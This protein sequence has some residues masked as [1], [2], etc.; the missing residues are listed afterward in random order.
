MINQRQYSLIA[1]SY[2]Q[3]LFNGA[4]KQGTLQRV[5]DEAKGLASV[6]TK[7]PRLLVFLDNPRVATEKKLELISNSL[8]ARLSPLMMNLLIALIRR[9]R[10][11]QLPDVL[12]RFQ[13]LVEEAEGIQHA[14][15]ESAVELSFGDKL[16]LKGTL[17]KYTGS[18]LR[19]DYNVN[20]ALI[21]G[22]VFR[23]R[24]L[25]VDSS[26]SSGLADLRRRLLGAQL[27]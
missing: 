3:A 22:L 11:G 8:R 21:G 7:L 26:I 2:A 19:I 14:V 27:K 1:K 16:R 23:Y 13:E 6:A 9:D 12:A 10:T 15:V 17:E 24:D 20:P 5:G 4:R 18:R 25:L